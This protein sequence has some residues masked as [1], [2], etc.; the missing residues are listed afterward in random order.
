MKRTLGF[1]KFS[2]TINKK[3]TRQPQNSFLILKI[4][5]NSLSKFPQMAAI[6]PN[7]FRFAENI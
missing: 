4:A 7:P 5:G 3:V 1:G 2:N 6:D